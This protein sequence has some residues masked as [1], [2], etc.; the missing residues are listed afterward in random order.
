MGTGTQT[1][2]SGRQVAVRSVCVRVLMG[3]KCSS[4]GGNAVP[5]RESSVRGAV[6]RLNGDHTVT[7]A[8]RYRSSPS[9]S[10]SAVTRPWT[11]R[12]SRC[13]YVSDSAMGPH[14]RSR[15]SRWE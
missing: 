2:A 13:A 9:G 1:R 4:G 8:G 14:D 5:K 12:C 15:N 6:K 11:R 7:G 10:R 3:P